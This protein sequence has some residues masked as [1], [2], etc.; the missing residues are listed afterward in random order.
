MVYFH[1]GLPSPHNF[2]VLVFVI[3]YVHLFVIVVII[4]INV[5]IL[6]SVLDE[7]KKKENFRMEIA[8]II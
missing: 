4:R 5:S 2:V 7:D 8:A 1:D 3:Y 6:Y